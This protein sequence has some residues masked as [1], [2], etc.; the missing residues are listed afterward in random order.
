[1][2]CAPAVAVKNISIATA[3]LNKRKRA[4]LS[5]LFC[6]KTKFNLTFGEFTITNACKER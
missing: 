3:V 6:K 1:M 2:I 4:H 5:A